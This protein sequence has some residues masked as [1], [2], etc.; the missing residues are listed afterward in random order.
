MILSFILILQK[1]QFLLF[2]ILKG[3]LKV[4]LLLLMILELNLEASLLSQSLD[5][6]WVH[7]DTSNIALFESDTVLEELLVQLLHHVLR[8]VRFQVEHLIQEDRV[9]EV[10]DVFLEFGGQKLIKSTGT[11]S[12]HEH[13]HQFLVALWQSEREMD[14]HI[15][16]SIVFRWAFLNWCIIVNNVLG[17]QAHNSPVAA[18]EPMGTWSHKR[19]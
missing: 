17:K 2:L 14:V 4:L 19:K 8:H 6:L 7:V 11:K 12:V 15:Y 5:H 13:V 18:V 10:T 3:Q 1:S 16:E 9:D